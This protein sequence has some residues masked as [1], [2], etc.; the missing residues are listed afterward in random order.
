MENALERTTELVQVQWLPDTV[1]V[2]VRCA[3]GR[4]DGFRCKS[5]DDWSKPPFVNHQPKHTHT[6]THNLLVNMIY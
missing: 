6:H 2:W 1:S 5:G 3:T 4:A